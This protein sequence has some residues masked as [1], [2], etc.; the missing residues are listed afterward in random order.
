MSKYG[1]LRRA[2]CA[3][4]LR[5]GM[6][7][8][9]SRHLVLDSDHRRWS[10]LAPPDPEFHYD[11]IEALGVFLAYHVHGPTDRVS[12]VELNGVLEEEDLPA[13]PSASEWHEEFMHASP[14]YVEQFL[15]AQERMRAAHGE[16]AELARRME[17]LLLTDGSG[18]GGSA[19][20]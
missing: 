2:S 18:R 3:S 20:I 11:V 1:A 7:Q 12:R 15:A 4:W 16:R 6:H 19:V 10:A 17:Q 13:A 5:Q 14:T 9:L 8:R